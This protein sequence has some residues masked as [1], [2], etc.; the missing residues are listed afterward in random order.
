[1]KAEECNVQKAK[2]Y[3]A[4]ALEHEPSLIASN[5]STKALLD[6]EVLLVQSMECSLLVFSAHTELSRILLDMKKDPDIAK[7]AF[8]AEGKA[9]LCQAAWSLV[10]DAHCSHVCVIAAP[11]AIALACAVLAAHLVKV[12][13][14]VIDLLLMGMS[15]AVLSRSS[16]PAVPFVVLASVTSQ[17]STAR[18]SL[19]LSVHRLSCTVCLLWDVSAWCVL[20]VEC[21]RW[22][23]G[24]HHDGDELF[25]IMN[26]ITTTLA[27]PD[28]SPDDIAWR[29]RN[30]GT[31]SR[32]KM[33]S[34]LVHCELA[35]ST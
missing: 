13:S 30:L 34:S 33:L 19:G 10:C 32:Q 8:G 9:D 23:C 5:F 27:R 16:F 21:F 22:L 31:V 14:I 25:R 29:M 15:N 2:V 24:V 7:A 35:C 11:S 26:V 20:Q 12:G 1:V 6:R 4:M 28:M 18:D 17:A 3:T